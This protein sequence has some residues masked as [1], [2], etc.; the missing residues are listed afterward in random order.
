[1]NSVG[2]LRNLLE[3]RQILLLD[4]AFGPCTCGICHQL[5]ASCGFDGI[6]QLSRPIAS[7]WC[8]SPAQ[9]IS[10][11]KAQSRRKAHKPL[12]TS[13]ISHKLCL[14]CL[15]IIQSCYFDYDLRFVLCSR[16]LDV[17]RAQRITGFFL[18]QL[19]TNQRGQ[20]P[21]STSNHVIG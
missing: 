8:S 21:L 19:P 10:I 1:M 7:V 9:P 2:Y 13:W 17:P 16:D 6:F 4:A 5:S 20:N 15:I 3:V 11:R 12:R 18:S 14:P